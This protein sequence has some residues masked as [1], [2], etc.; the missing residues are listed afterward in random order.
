[1]PPLLLFQ[2]TTN[3][4]IL[5]KNPPTL[6]NPRHTNKW[7][8]GSINSGKPTTLQIIAAPCPA[9]RLPGLYGM[10]N[11]PWM[12]RHGEMLIAPLYYHYQEKEEEEEEGRV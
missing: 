7:Q 4:N 8:I 5:G 12:D 11:L 3:N 1:M 9:S 10:Q 2:H 6:T